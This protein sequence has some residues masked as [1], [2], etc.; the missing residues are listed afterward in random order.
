MQAFRSNLRGQN[1]LSRNRLDECEAY[2]ISLH[3][4]HFEHSVSLLNLD[5]RR[6]FGLAAG[7]RV[8]NKKLP[9]TSYKSALKK[10]AWAKE[11]R[12]CSCHACIFSV[13]PDR[14]RGE[15]VANGKDAARRQAEDVH[16][17][18]LPAGSRNGLCIVRA[19]VDLDCDDQARFFGHHRHGWLGVLR[20]ASMQAD[21][22]KDKGQARDR[23]P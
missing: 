11:K 8:S 10:I 22:R 7:R 3:V 17:Y 15:S 4:A 5:S 16:G 9:E 18:R 23:L 1:L 6:N 13:N 2:H 14:M 12:D 19:L 20:R 21:A